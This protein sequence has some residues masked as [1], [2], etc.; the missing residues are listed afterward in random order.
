[1]RNMFAY[2]SLCLCSLHVALATTDSTPLVRVYE[3]ALNDTLIADIQEEIRIL[4]DRRRR[5]RRTSS[6]SENENVVYPK[7]FWIP[8]SS[9]PDAYPSSFTSTTERRNELAIEKAV[10]TLYRVAYPEEEEEGNDIIGAEF[11]AQVKKT[12]EFIH[13][14]FDKDEFTFQTQNIMRTPDLSTVTYLTNSGGP[15]LIFDQHVRENQTTFPSE[16]TRSFAVW[17]KTGR[18]CVFRGDMYHVVRGDMARVFGDRYTFIVNWW[19]SELNEGDRRALRLTPALRKQYRALFA[20]RRD[21][22]DEAAVDVPSLAAADMQRPMRLNISVLEP[23]NGVS[24]GGEETDEERT[25]ALFVPVDE[26]GERSFHFRFPSWQRFHSNEGVGEVR[27]RSFSY[28]SSL[29]SFPADRND[30]DIANDTFE[31][32]RGSVILSRSN[33]FV[34]RNVFHHPD[35]E[36]IVAFVEMD[37]IVRVDRV[38][39]QFVANRRGRSCD[40][41]RNQTCEGA[42][43]TAMDLSSGELATTSSSLVSMVCDAA[44]SYPFLSLFGLRRDQLP[45]VAFV[46]GTR[47][48]RQAD[49]CLI[50]S[51]DNNPNVAA[52]RRTNVSVASIREMVANCVAAQDSSDADDDADD[53]YF[54][55]R[56]PR[57]T[58]S[59]TAWR[60]RR[61]RDDE[62]LGFDVDFRYFCGKA[63]L[64]RKT[65]ARPSST[66]C[67]IHFV[68][69][70]ESVESKSL[71]LSV[72]Q[73]VVE[74]PR[75]LPARKSY[76]FMHVRRRSDTARRLLSATNVSVLRD[77]PRGDFLVAVEFLTGNDDIQS[78]GTSVQA[79][80]YPPPG[81]AKSPLGLLS[82]QDTWR[83]PGGASIGAFGGFVVGLEAAIWGDEARVADG[84]GLG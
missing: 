17:P 53:G 46:R 71:T 79:R 31:A 78:E 5:L 74:S 15:T 18:H 2:L 59:I 42:K 40:M 77:Y 55:T 81:G 47:W 52:G 16:P 32:F 33:P 73:S 34:A 36:K 60:R 54:L 58:Q 57:P 19:T 72:L 35:I 20:S 82:L 29:S 50:K 48:T 25:I 45:A 67:V 80:Q 24:E 84:A 51:S 3:G 10:K 11:W 7:S 70:E 62:S 12:G 64:L 38:L 30:R 13:P 14:H 83:A 27:F 75:F 65:L 37:D 26:S 61:L 44:H 68:D 69:E 22:N 6:T 1:M 49:L 76:E 8:L 43:D 28:P 39:R 66:V 9:S 41:R 63:S 23:Q 56:P 21:S 4:F